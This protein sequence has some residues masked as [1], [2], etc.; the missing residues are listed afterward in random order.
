MNPARCPHS[1]RAALLGLLLL[2]CLA[3][4][5]GAAAAPP[6]ND[7]RA[8]A[9]LFDGFGDT[10]REATT[11]PGENLSPCDDQRFGRTVWYTINITDPSEVKIE[12]F[13]DSDDGSELDTVIALYSGSS[14]TRIDCN[15]NAPSGGLGSELTARLNPGTYQVQVGGRTYST[16]PD[17]GVFNVTLDA[18]PIPLN[19][20]RAQATE[21][22]LNDVLE[23]ETNRGAAEE[24]GEDLNCFDGIPDPEPSPFGNTVWYA[25]T[26]PAR[27][28]VTVTTQGTSAF[29]GVLDT[30]ASLYF[31]SGGKIACNDDA[32]GAGNVG[33]SRIASG[34]L[35][36]GR[37]LVQVGGFGAA[38]SDRGE[39]SVALDFREDLDFDGDSF[40]R[41]PG[42]D[43]NDNNPG[44]NPNAADV[45]YNGVDEDCRG[46][47]DLDADNDGFNRGP[48]CDDANPGMNPG[49]REIKGNFVDENCDGSSPAAR[50]S[51]T[52]DVIFPRR[53][54]GRRGVQALSLRVTR[55]TRG[56]R[57]TV[58]CKGRG[59]P[60]TQRRT[61]KSSRPITFRAY[62]KRLIRNGGV[63]TVYVTRPGAN[64]L[65]QYF[66]Y[67]L[68]TKKLVDVSD[69]CLFPGSLRIRK[70][71]RT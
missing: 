69:G 12:A 10:N 40:N 36:A 65:G 48:D 45:P 58:R 31:A 71:C 33:F 60:R 9:A 24:T 70:N 11:E 25:F 62:R 18:I 19:D 44:I 47:D 35:P 7:N 57:V 28:S 52:P 14:T 51:P 41:A 38:S 55:V 66:R 30:V 26:L 42:P 20:A 13:G 1:P 53:P 59:C 43:C 50:L 61:A 68:S 49:T 3:F 67:R 2:A 46:G 17:V 23:F 22:P 63:L 56:H 4:P 5:A 6:P 27:G 54:I 21:V 37:Y 39:F 34:E 29:G 64:V 15:D 16:G 8:N 32:S